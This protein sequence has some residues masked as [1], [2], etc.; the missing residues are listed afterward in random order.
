MLK[1]A[2]LW[3]PREGGKV[4]CSLCSHRCEIAAGRS[5]ICGVRWNQEGTLV[6]RAYG[7]V[8]AIHVDPIEKKPLH[9]FYPGS[10]ALS[11]ATEGCNFRCAFCQNWQISQ[12]PRKKG[13]LRG[14]YRLSPEEIV[15]EALENECRSISY[16]YTEPT[17]FF[18]YAYDTAKLAGE[19]GLANTFVTN[20]YM[21]EEGL[22]TI[23]PY[24]DGANVDLKFF[25][26]E[27]YRKICGAS[28]EPVLSTI[29]LMKKM[30]IWIEITTLVVPGLNDGE[31]ELRDIAAFIAGVDPDIP[32]H[33][34]RFHPDYEYT[35]APAT[36]TATLK[37]AQ[38]VGENEGLK[39]I[40]IGNLLGES[41]DTKCPNCGRIVVRRLGFDVVSTELAGSKCAF[42]GTPIAGVFDEGTAE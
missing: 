10:K 38:A 2:R 26:E 27:T 36:P 24:L 17:V 18:E 41:E 11:I 42:C 33:V 32:W 29:R 34:S 6:T 4:A 22:T 9:H 39:H 5:G 20:G 13:S 35:D 14:T 30:G 28:L 1:D 3:T 21:T 40:Y 19:K 7:E 16:T 23:E 25:N 8:I 31:E 12:A 15:R 37:A